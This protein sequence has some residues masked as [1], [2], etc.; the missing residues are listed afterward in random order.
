[1]YGIPFL[2]GNTGSLYSPYMK[3]YFARLLIMSC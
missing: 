1:M 3:A 2:G